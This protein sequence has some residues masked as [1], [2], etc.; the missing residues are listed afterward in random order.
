[1]Y[2]YTDDTFFRRTSSGVLLRKHSLSYA[3]DILYKI[4]PAVDMAAIFL[5]T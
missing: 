3:R 4:A 2:T 5:S 1:M